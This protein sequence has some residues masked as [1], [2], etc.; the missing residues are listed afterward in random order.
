MIITLLIYRSDIVKILLKRVDIDVNL[1]TYYGTTALTYAIRN[2]N[3]MA[4]KE[5]IKHPRI[6]INY[7]SKHG[8][9]ALF[10]AVSYKR[11]DI[12][13]ILLQNSTCE[14]DIVDQHDRTPFLVACQYG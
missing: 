10:E 9:N 7:Q 14:V 3:V 12:V 13:D 1:S 11:K 8:E 4:V 5:L 2:G 6:N